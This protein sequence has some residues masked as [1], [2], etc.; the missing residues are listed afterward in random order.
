V[1]PYDLITFCEIWFNAPKVRAEVNV[2]NIRDKADLDRWSEI[3]TGV[4]RVLDSFI[5]K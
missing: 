1:P 2:G 3:E 5:A 4:L